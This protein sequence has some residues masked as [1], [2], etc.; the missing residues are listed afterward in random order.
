MK[1]RKVVTFILVHISFIINCQVS[2]SYVNNLQFRGEGVVFTSEYTPN[3]R[4]QV[5]VKIFTPSKN[6]IFRAEEILLTRFNTDVNWTKKKTPAK[7]KFWKYNR[8]YL[9]VLTKKGEKKII[10]QL[11]NFKCKR[12][13]QDNFPNWRNEYVIGFGEYYEKNTLRLEANITSESL[14]LY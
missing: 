9:G 12:K 3:F 13:A 2:F 7:K 5:G 1:M 6:D 4:P 11:L 8:Q 10:I 14:A